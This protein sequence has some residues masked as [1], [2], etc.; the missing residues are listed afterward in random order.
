[1]R[2]LGLLSATT[3]LLAGALEACAGLL[4][5]EEFHEI[6]PE[7]GAGPEVGDADH[8]SRDVAIAEDGGSTNQGD[9]CD[10]VIANT[11]VTTFASN[12]S[13]LAAGEGHTCAVLE[14]GGNVKCWGRNADGELG[15]GSSAASPTPVD[16]KRV[17]H[18]QS[19]S[20]GAHHTCAAGDT[21]VACWGSNGS[22][23][24]GVGNR[25][26]ASEPIAVLNPVASV[27]A[28][29]QHTCAR[30]TDSSIWCWGS[31]AAGQFGDDTRTSKSTPVQ[32]NVSGDT[33]AAAAG[34]SGS[35]GH[36]CVVMTGGGSGGVVQCS[37]DNS[38]GQLGRGDQTSTTVPVVVSE[39]MVDRVVLGQ[40]F[41]CGLLR[42][43]SV[44]C[45]GANDRGQLGNGTT[46]LSTKAVGISTLTNVKALSAGRSH[47][48][49]VLSDGTLMCWGANESG[50]LGTG[51]APMGLAPAP[52][53]GVD[54][55]EQV[56]AGAAHTCA[57][58][59]GRR[60]V[61]CWGSNSDGQRGVSVP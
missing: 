20:A 42:S 51:V 6:H 61:K 44:S 39:L 10:R 13:L 59:K 40:S 47:A 17:A 52:V 41:S 11:G 19:I 55:V 29:D 45:W 26:S 16:V 21:V 28:A 56:A 58:L 5:I 12:V 1:V 2:R 24:L 37:G 34:G 46:T 3:L 60:T 25:P 8:E 23:Q 54:S 9:A 49:A 30:K 18:V 32:M 15:N 43:G 35:A 36:S 27:A 31:N 53:C 48:C 50:Q 57:L 14:S 4:G 38:S 7:A 22:G 33:V